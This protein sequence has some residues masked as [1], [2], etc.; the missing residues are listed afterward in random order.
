MCGLTSVF[1]TDAAIR[2]AASALKEE[3]EA[4]LESI[5]HRGPDSRGIYISPDVRVG[6]S[7]FHCLCLA[8]TAVNCRTRTCAIV[9]N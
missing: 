3:L 6:L 1:H 4:S 2:P 9:N 7:L 5:K 8:F